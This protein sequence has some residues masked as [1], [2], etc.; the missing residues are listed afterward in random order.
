[1]ATLA[2]LVIGIVSVVYASLSD[3]ISIRT[4][5]IYGVFLIIIGSL[6]GYIFLQQFALVLAGR[7]IQ[8]SGLAAAE[9]LYVIY[10]AK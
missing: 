8:S 2:G 7:I 9:T 4:L 1:Q 6:I 5:F 10:V 3:E